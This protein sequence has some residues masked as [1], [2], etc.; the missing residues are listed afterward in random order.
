MQM[1]KHLMENPLSYTVAMAPTYVGRGL[2]IN[3]RGLL[4]LTQFG[5]E[6]AVTGA[7]LEVTPAPTAVRVR[8][9]ILRR[10]FFWGCLLGRRGYRR[11]S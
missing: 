9:N 7:Y 11:C 1:R 5:T 8:A 10:G 6:A 4:Q 2:A 3:M